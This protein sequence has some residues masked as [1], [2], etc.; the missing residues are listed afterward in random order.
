MNKEASSR[1]GFNQG[2]ALLK[3]KKSFCFSLY[4]KEVVNP[5]LSQCRKT[6]P[7]PILNRS[8]SPPFPMGSPA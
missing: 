3:S 6:T 4:K 2:T 1:V 7:F 8:H 5:S